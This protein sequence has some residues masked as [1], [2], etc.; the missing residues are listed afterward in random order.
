[1][2]VNERAA[3][4]RARPPKG[5]H[6]VEPEG[7]HRRAANEVSGANIPTPTV[8][9]SEMHMYQT[10]ENSPPPSL[11]VYVQAFSAHPTSLYVV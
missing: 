1:M 2:E 6:E 3:F 5:D 10:R 11:Y 9:F 4:A 8:V 7:V